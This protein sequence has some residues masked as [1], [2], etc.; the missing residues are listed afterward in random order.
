ME[1]TTNKKSK[2]YHAG[3]ATQR[4]ERALSEEMGIQIAEDAP[5]TVKLRIDDNTC[6]FS[7]DTSG[8]P[9]HK[10]GHKAAVGKAPMRETMAAM[11]LRE[12]G[13]DGQEPVLD[14]MCGS[15]TFV[16]EAAEIARGLAPGR[17]RRFAF[18]QLAT[19]DP[20]DW[21]AIKS[22]SSPKPSQMRFY[23]SDRNAGAI[24]MS[25]QNAARADV[26][27]LCTF[28]QLAMG[29]VRP[30]EG[31]PGLVMI[32][33]PYGA[34]IGNKKLLFALHG[35]MGK[36]LMERFSG[37]RVGIVTSDSGLAKATKLPFLPTGAP[38]AHG[39]LKVRLFRTDP[40][41]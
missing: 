41:P 25:A 28:Q 22:Q 2:I 40:L 18:E 16:L 35:T 38:V 4:I 1:T 19:F 10:R 6:V 20:V 9:L 34:R 31:A 8:E 24:E 33:P 39:G 30:P 26:A 5:I 27:E 3:A 14:P 13:F 21:E 29:D 36:V 11:F 15:G 17:S 23:G 7:V 12:C 32:N 37:W